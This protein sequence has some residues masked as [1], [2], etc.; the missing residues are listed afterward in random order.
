MPSIFAKTVS[1]PPRPRRKL[2]S[3][4]ILVGLGV[5]LVQLV[6]VG[7]E[8]VP[9]ELHVPQKSAPAHTITPFGLAAPR[10]CPGELRPRQSARPT[11]LASLIA[12]GGAACPIAAP[13]AISWADGSSRPAARHT[14]AETSGMPSQAAITRIIRR[15]SRRIAGGPPARMVASSYWSPQPPT[16]RDAGAG[17]T[18][19][20]RARPQPRSEATFEAFQMDDQLAPRPA[21][22]NVGAGRC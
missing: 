19:W 18:F 5:P 17:S 20:S 8:Q 14:G 12:S 7:R 10:R 15:V 9:V 6:A 22:I 1:A 4:R 3:A 2:Q 16:N 13:S 21:R 11:P